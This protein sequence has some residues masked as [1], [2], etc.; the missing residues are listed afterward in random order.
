L[1]KT[2]F[3]FKLFHREY[4][5]YWLPH[6]IQNSIASD[7]QQTNTAQW[8]GNIER[9]LMGNIESYIEFTQGKH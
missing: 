7:L 3:N 2:D 8:Y 9:N 6:N 1:E 5:V 4:L